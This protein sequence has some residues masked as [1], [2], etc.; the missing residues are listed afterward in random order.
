M[1]KLITKTIENVSKKFPLYSQDGKKGEA[2]VLARFFT[3]Y[4]R[5]YTWYMLEYDTSSGD[6]F[7][8]VVGPEPEY[9]YF[10]VNELQD[11]LLDFKVGGLIVKLQ[12]VESDVRIV[13]GE[14]SLAD[15]LKRHS[16]PE[17]RWWKEDEE[18][19]LQNS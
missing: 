17:P 14:D 3:P 5:N 18:K 12:A 10:N 9:G 1:R 7:G 6:A 15:L 13:P 11:I 2:K 16:D 4:T 19:T 8:Y